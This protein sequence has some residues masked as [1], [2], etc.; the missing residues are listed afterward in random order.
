MGPR[1]F[2]H[3]GVT[4]QSDPTSGARQ[5]APPRA[6]TAS[7]TRTIPPRQ[8]AISRIA[9]TAIHPGDHPLTAAGNVVGLWAN[10]QGDDCAGP[11][12]ACWPHIACRISMRQRR[13]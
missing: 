8:F 4:L 10:C 5:Y 6:T 7:F 12:W 2:D 3:N 13:Y 1:T 9:K 11:V